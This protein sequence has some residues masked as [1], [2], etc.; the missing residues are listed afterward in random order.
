MTYIARTRDCGIMHAS[1][2]NK[3]SIG[4]TNSVFS[5]SLD[6]RKSTSSYVF[7]IGSGVISWASKKQPFL[8]LS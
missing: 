2:E 4:F 8:T 6:D 3:V 5:G 7:H 1:T